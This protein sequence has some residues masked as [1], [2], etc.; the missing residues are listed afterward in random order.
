MDTGPLVALLLLG[1]LAAA[2]AGWVRRLAVA[3]APLA[4]A[5]LALAALLAA[6]SGRVDAGR[7]QVT[8]L[9]VLAG[10]LAVAGGGPVTSRVFALVDGRGHGDDPGS[11]HRAGDVLRGGAWIGALERAAIFASLAVGQPEGVAIVLGL[12]GLGRYPE[13]RNDEKAGAAE[14]IIIG[15]FASVLWAAACAGVVP[16]LV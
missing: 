5:G 13:L 8:L 16:L 6:A 14:R 4:L 10:A 2:A 11:I 1:A 15:T 3:A 12:K 9:V 7:G